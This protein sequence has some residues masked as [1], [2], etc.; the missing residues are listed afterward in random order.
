[1]TVFYVYEHTRQDTG[2]VFYVGKGSGNRC[3]S[4]LGRNIYWH[5][6][7]KK[8][9]GFNVLKI[10]ENIDEDFAFLIEIERIDQLKRL[11]YA[12]TNLTSGGE[13]TSG[14]VHSQETKQKLSL[15]QLGKPKGPM[16]ESTKQKLSILKTGVLRGPMPEATKSK[17]KFA[18]M[19]IKHSQES[20]AQMAMKKKG[21]ALSAEHKKILSS[22]FAGKNNPNYGKKHNSIAI[23]KIRQS[24]LNAKKITC[25]YCNKIGDPSNMARWH[26]KNCK[27]KGNENE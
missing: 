14:L 22:L 20:Y 16:Q 5:R 27:H 12:L 26:F 17:I 2:A 13:G 24:R 23:E 8:I 11:G 6:V 10:V 7:V 19:G 3:F 1:M 21:V 9:N 18:N 4:K 25:P 15:A